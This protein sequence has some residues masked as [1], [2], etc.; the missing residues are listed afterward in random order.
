MKLIVR[1]TLRG[2]LP[3]YECLKVLFH[4]GI[5]D[6]Q[7]LVLRGCHVDKIRLVLRTFLIE[8]L[9][10]RL[11]CRGFSQV[12]TDDLVQRFSQMR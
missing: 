10:H 3:C 12:C 4:T 9:V 6:A 11:I 7:E 8:E 2:I 5:V 1:L